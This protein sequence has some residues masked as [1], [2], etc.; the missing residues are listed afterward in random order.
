MKQPSMERKYLL[1]NQQ[2]ITNYQTL[3]EIF[4]K[5]EATSMNLQNA[6]LVKQFKWK[7]WW[8]VV[9]H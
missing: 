5:L 9:E 3:H 1:N 4:P 2:P 8:D 6:W 7:S